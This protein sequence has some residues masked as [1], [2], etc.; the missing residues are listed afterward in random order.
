M[1]ATGKRAWSDLPPEILSMIGNR[2]HTR[3]DV[4]RFRGVCSSFR[5]SIPQPRR[6]ASRFPFP[7]PSLT[8]TPGPA[9]FLRA[10][11]VYAVETPDEAA[12]SGRT[13]WL[14]KLEESELGRMRILSLYSHRRIVYL[15]HKF[16]KVLDSL[17]FRIVEISRQYTLE[18]GGGTGALVQYVQ[19]VVMHPDCVGSDVD[20][21]SVY[22]IDYKGRLGYWRY[23][24]EKW[25]HLDDSEGGGYDDI[26]V[27][28]GRVCVINRLGSVSEI[29]SSFGLRS[30]SLPIYS[31]FWKQLVVSSGDLYV[32]DKCIRPGAPSHTENTKITSGFRVYRLDRQCGRWEVVRSLGDSAFFL[33]KH[34]SFAVSALELGGRD[35]NCIY[36]ADSTFFVTR[37]KASRCS[38]WRILA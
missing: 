5:S 15:P 34:C 31:G 1:E 8:S 33:C 4:L 32:V 12:P 21:C 9:L 24:D 14:L 16:P 28:E 17:Q 23:G 25:S 30:L 29:D 3:M 22:F 26:A 7:I 13:R 11:T 2:L 36:Y 10:S 18:H 37:W 38:T 20:R 19:K 27:Y 35:K 6:D